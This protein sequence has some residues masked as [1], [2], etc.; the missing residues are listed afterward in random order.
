LPEA[1]SREDL[2]ITTLVVGA[3]AENAYVIAPSSGGECAVIDPGAEGA[4]IVEAVRAA[5]LTVRYI[6]TTHGHADHTGGAAAVKRELGGIYVAHEADAGMILSPDPWIVELLG[7]FEIPPEIDLKVRGGETLPIGDLNVA[8]I[9]TPGHTP[10]S[11]CYRCDN[12][13]FTGDTLFKGSIGRY[14]LPGGDGARELRSIHEQLL[15][16]PGDTRVLPGHG[17]ATSIEAER[18][19]NPFLRTGP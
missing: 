1:S 10:G 14:D 16:L 18:R 12:V 2:R 13:V 4:R 9:A 8:I 3:F 5:G 15:T 6:L 7:A 11:V 17:P 19:T